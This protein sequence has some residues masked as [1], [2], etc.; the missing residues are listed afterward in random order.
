M[1]GGFK[2]PKLRVD[3]EGFELKE[4]LDLSL[5]NVGPTS[6]G[7]NQK[8]GK[9][10][11]PRSGVVS[12][13]ATSS[14]V[15]LGASSSGMRSGSAPSSET[16]FREVPAKESAFRKEERDNIATMNIQTAANLQEVKLNEVLQSEMESRDVKEEKFGLQSLQR[17]PGFGQSSSAREAK[18]VTPIQSMPA[19]QNVGA[20]KSE[21]EYKYGNSSASS[22]PKLN[23]VP[24]KG[25]GSSSRKKEVNRSDCPTAAT[26]SSQSERKMHEPKEGQGDSAPPAEAGTAGIHEGLDQPAQCCRCL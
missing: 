13:C 20:L 1:T 14:E 22:E 10:G 21:R 15:K 25:A 9:L 4:E 24:S 12:S 8:E 3:V 23:E 18:L 2:E 19:A 17:D 6:A 11:V 16:K 26:G 7:T 5:T